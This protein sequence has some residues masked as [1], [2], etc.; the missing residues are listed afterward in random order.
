MSNNHISLLNPISPDSPRSFRPHPYTWDSHQGSKSETLRDRMH[1]RYRLEPPKRVYTYVPQNLDHLE[2]CSKAAYKEPTPNEIHQLTWRAN[3]LKWLYILLML[4]ISW[5]VVSSLGRL[6][7]GN[8][9]LVMMFLVGWFCV[10]KVRNFL[11]SEDEV[12][13][14]ETKRFLGLQ[15]L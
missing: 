1:Q 13:T 15:D 8:V 9:V 6:T 4:L 14:K 11:D 7:G 12:P 3:A 5:S 10:V 2:E